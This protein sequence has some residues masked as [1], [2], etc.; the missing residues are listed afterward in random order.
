M[1]FQDPNFPSN[2]TPIDVVLFP[3]AYYVD[4]DM[5]GKR[6]LV[7]SPNTTASCVD[8]ESVWH[9]QNTGT[10]GNPTF[11]FSQTDL[12]QGRMIDNGVGA[13]PVFFDHDGDGL[14]DLI[15]ANS[16]YYNV[17]DVVNY[18]NL[19]YYKNTGTSVLPE[20]TFVTNNYAGLESM[21]FNL[22]IYPTF[23]DVD[24]DGD[25]DMY[26]GG[27][28]G[29]I[30]FFE[31]IA[32]A[33]NPAVFAAPVL[34]VIDASGAIIDVGQY[35]T[36]L[37]KDMNRDGKL[38][39]VIGC[40]LGVLFYYENTGTTVLPKYSLI[41]ATLGG[42]NTTEANGIYGY[43]VPSIVDVNGAYEL[44]LGAYSGFLHHYTDLDANLAGN[45]TLVDTLYQGIRDGKQSGVAVED[46]DGD[47]N[48]E[49]YYGTKRG[50][51]TLY[52]SNSDLGVYDHTGLDADFNVYP[53]PTSNSIVVDFSQSKNNYYG[54]ELIIY[55]AVGQ[56]ILSRKVVQNKIQ[57][58]LSNYT[59]GVYI[60]SVLIDGVQLNKKLIK[61]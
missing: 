1:G 15:V 24:N 33:G 40:K 54:S 28:F 50:G 39:L 12:L 16:Y 43:S 38:D 42:V 52:E 14:K 41:T 37:L 45:F 4:I 55:N 19:T 13:Y 9:Y 36:P 56:V 22:N 20:F 3:A 21:G 57:I 6:E 34:N 5:D 7:V 30:H 23:G 2:T 31:N 8:M 35:S 44:F 17:T 60:L 27:L 49:L 53:N 51:I 29:G 61:K 25:E 11:I 59:Q 58:D 46:M 26:L 18:S 32:G 48:F 10:D 47:G